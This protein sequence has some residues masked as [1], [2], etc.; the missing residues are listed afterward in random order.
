M[1]AACTTC[2][3]YRRARLASQLLGALFDTNSEGAEIAQALAKVSEDEHKLRDAEAETKG[4]EGLAGR[5]LWGAR[6]MTSDFCGLEEDAG[7]YRIAEVKNR[8]LSCT[9]HT[10]GTPERRACGDC[11][12]RVPAEGRRQDV[13]VEALYTGLI[14]QSVAAH[15]SGQ[16]AQALLQSHRAAET[17]KKAL[18]ISAAYESKG[19]LI[20][21]PAYVDHCGKFST[22]DEFVVCV[23]HNPHNTCTEWT[24]AEPRASTTPEEAA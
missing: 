13:R 16:T 8:G 19:R 12:H 22:P 9:D 23:L 5:D 2:I 11:A 17:S 14:T 20:T 21:K 24:P 3:H 18:E 1:G 4:P 15:G 10:T 7:I 6:P